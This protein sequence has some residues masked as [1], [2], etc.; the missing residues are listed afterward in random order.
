[1]IKVVL[2]DDHPVVRRGIK[3]MLSGETD[4]YVVGEVDS[5]GD[6]LM[7]MVNSTQPDVVV[8][9]VKMPGHNLVSSVKALKESPPGPK[10]LI[11]SGFD[12]MEY[13]LS[14]LEVGVSGYLLKDEDP[15]TLLAAIRA[16]AKGETWLSPQL[17]GK[18]VSARLLRSTLSEREMEVLGLIAQGYNTQQIAEELYLSP[19]TVQNHVSSIYS[20][21]NINSRVEAAKYAMEMGIALP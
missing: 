11:L 1:M 8:L 19:R 9:D 21:L 13:V 18:V 5:G 14:T 4:I 6:Q 3:S 10:V 17:S 15:R 7:E 20:K 12:N 16:V 2:A